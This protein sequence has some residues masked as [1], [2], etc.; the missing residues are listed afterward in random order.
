MENYE[1][2]LIW[3]PNLSE[4]DRNSSSLDLKKL[5]KKNSIKIEK[6]DVWGNKKLAYKINGS[7]KGF[8]TLL[9]LE[10]DGKLI[11]SLSK[12]INLDKS[13]WRYMFVKKEA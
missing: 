7:E 10:M 6:E 4:E 12:D 13:I 9:D 3:D 11:K 8:Y 5:F 2:M 1:L